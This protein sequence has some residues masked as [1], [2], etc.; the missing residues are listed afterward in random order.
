MARLISSSLE[1]ARENYAAWKRALKKFQ[2]GAQSYEIGNRT[3]ERVNMD[4]VV[5]MIDRFALEIEILEG[6]RSARGTRQVVFRD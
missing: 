3:L 5:K 4:E 6:R 2:D 1:E